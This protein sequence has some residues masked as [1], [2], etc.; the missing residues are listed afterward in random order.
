MDIVSINA[1]S[2]IASIA[3]SI[4]QDPMS[5]Q[6]WHA[7]CIKFPE[8]KNDMAQD[9]LIWAKSIFASYLSG[10]EGRAYFFQGKFLHVICRD[11][12]LDILNQTASQICDLTFI[13]NGL[14]FQFQI[15]DLSRNGFEYMQNIMESLGNILG[16]PFVSNVNTTTKVTRPTITDLDR[17]VWERRITG[18]LSGA[19]VLLV[20]D[21]PVTRWMV[22]NALKGECMLAT[23][24]CANQA[25]SIYS[26]FCPDIVFLDIDLPDKSGLCVLEWIVSND[27]GARVVM[28]SS[29]NSLDT[30]S[31]A[32]EVGA[33]GFVAKP[34]LKDNL[35]YY[36]RN[37]Q[38]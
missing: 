27:P 26:A 19:K 33:K 9:C 21:D 17:Q 22:R 36:I 38:I 24:P 37:N 29:H 20:E 28:F 11:T 25:F 7:L 13:E 12:H 18:G 30:I 10:T 14:H 8:M 31:G 5:W 16:R 32:L 15:Y 4:G 3:A 35:L 23:A 6:G 34:F 1:E 2:R